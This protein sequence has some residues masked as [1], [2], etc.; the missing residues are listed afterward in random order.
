MKSIGKI[1]SAEGGFAV[2]EIEKKSACTGDCSSCSSCGGGKKVR[3]RV[4]NKC[5]AAPG[6][7]VYIT[8]PGAKAFAL[9]AITYILPLMIF[10]IASAFIKNE[11]AQAAV[12]LSSFAVTAVS[13]NLLAKRKCF[14][15]V[16]ERIKNADF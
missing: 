13:A 4:L 5:G 11:I 15:S 6:E 2:A 16:T 7:T 8:L 12:L 1:V 14:M 9:A 10:F 3:V